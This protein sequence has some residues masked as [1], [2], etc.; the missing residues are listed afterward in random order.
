MNETFLPLFCNYLSGR[1]QYVT[2]GRCHSTI[3]PVTLGVPQGS[4]LVPI[5][6]LVFINDLPKALQHSVANT[7]AD[8]TTISHYTDYQAA[9]E[10]LQKNIDEV[11]NWS[12]SIKMLFNESKTKP[13]LITENDWRGRWNFP[14]FS[15]V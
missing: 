7:Y 1:S 6:F 3:R 10:G 15:Y 2:M 5:L 14:P 4:I 11:V 8:D 13:M 9:S 12:S